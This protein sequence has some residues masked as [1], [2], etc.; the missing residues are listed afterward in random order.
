MLG[1]KPV[2]EIKGDKF[3]Y[4]SRITVKD[5]QVMNDKL[6]QYEEEIYPYFDIFI[7]L[8]PVELNQVYQWRL[9]Q[10]N[11]MKATRG[12]NGLSD[13]QVKDFVETY[14]PAYELYL[15]R[16][17]KVGFFSQGYEGESLKPYEG[18]NRSDKGYSQPKRHLRIVLDSDRK[19]TQCLPLVESTSTNKMTESR[20]TKS[21][22]SPGNNLLFTKSLL[23][24]C[25]FMGV[26]AAAGIFG[27]KRHSIMNSFFKFSKRLNKK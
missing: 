12:V 9:Q 21:P 4:T 8:S 3:Q 2:I 18:L 27:Y 20:I 5:A 26:I 6:K 10:E 13:K 15:P 24:K 16:L 23:Y 14:M 7:H 25:A 17:D 11:H 22:I 1:F 19:V